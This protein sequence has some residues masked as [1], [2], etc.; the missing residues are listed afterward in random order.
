M[1]YC[2]ECQAICRLELLNDYL[3]KNDVGNQQYAT[4]SQWKIEEELCLLVIDLAPSSREYINGYTIRDDCFKFINSEPTT[5][6]NNY[7]NLFSLTEHFFLMNG[8][9]D[10]SVYIVCSEIA[11][12]FTLKFPTI[13]GFI[14]PTVQGNTGYNFVLRPH[15]IDNKMI[16]P[17]SVSMEKW[18]VTNNNSSNDD[19]QIQKGHIKGNHIIWD[20]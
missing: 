5:I 16:V 20:A 2:S 15:T 8:K 14:Y 13:D 3:L 18:T 11:N 6:Q 19:E 9:K 7:Y 17:E 1:F 4:Y 10:Y 12:Y